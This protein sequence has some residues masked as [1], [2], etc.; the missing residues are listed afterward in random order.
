MIHSKCLGSVHGIGML[1]AKGQMCSKVSYFIECWREENGVVRKDGMIDAR[2]EII[3]QVYRVEDLVLMLATGE[4]VPIIITNI[5]L[6]HAEIRIFG[7]VPG[8]V[9]YHDVS[10]TNSLSRSEF[11]AYSNSP[12]SR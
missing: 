6:G 5:E 7:P 4:A 9:H 10:D 11:A 3:E 2:N 12:R 8:L 1:L